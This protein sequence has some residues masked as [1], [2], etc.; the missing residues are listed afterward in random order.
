[1]HVVVGRPIEVKRN[2]QPT[3]DE[4]LI[5]TCCKVICGFSINV[6]VIVTVK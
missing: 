4:V 1:M 2:E 5:L 6:V 3:V